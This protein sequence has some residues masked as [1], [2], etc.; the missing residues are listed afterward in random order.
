VRAIS[1]ALHLVILFTSLF[2]L[3][4][5]PADRNLMLLFDRI[6]AHP[7]LSGFVVLYTLGLGVLAITQGNKE[8]FFYGLAMWVNIALVLLLD[9]RVGFT[10]MTLWA[11]AAWGLLHMAGGTVRIPESV[12]D[13]SKN[14]LYALRVADGLPRYDQCVHTF[15]FFAATLACAEV[16]MWT[17]GRVMMGRAECAEEGAHAR[18]EDGVGMP[19]GAVK[20]RL[21]LGLAC[22]AALMGMGLGALNEVIEFG[23]AMN[24]E[25]NGV[26]GYVN[27][28]WDLVCNMTGAVLAAGVEWGRGK[29]MQSPQ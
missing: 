4:A 10:W 9:A 3:H 24:V 18:A 20:P 25:G 11:L 23:I 29:A 13:G 16:L 7:F 17:V 2:T 1:T 21:T 15:G 22:G 12:T 8:F 14:V 26:G 27:T 28:G 5:R 19:P 6:R